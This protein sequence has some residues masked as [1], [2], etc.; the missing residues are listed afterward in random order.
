M[1]PYQKHFEFPYLLQIKSTLGVK[2]GDLG[3]QVIQSQI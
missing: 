3:G 2:A 1:A